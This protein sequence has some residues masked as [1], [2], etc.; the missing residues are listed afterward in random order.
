M[1]RNIKKSEKLGPRFMTPVF[2][3]KMAVSSMIALNTIFTEF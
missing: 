1:I 2:T 3:N